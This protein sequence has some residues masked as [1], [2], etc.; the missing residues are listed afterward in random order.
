MGP[1]PLG[2]I[3]APE[4]P[5]ADERDIVPEALAIQE[6]IV[7]EEGS[8]TRAAMDRFF[9]DARIAPPR[10]MEFT[11]NESI[12]QAVI[13]NMGLAFVSLHTASLELQTGMLVVLDVI[14][15]PLVRAWHVVS[16]EDESMSDAAESLRRFIV[17]FSGGFI[18]RQFGG[19][20]RRIGSMHTPASST[21]ADTG[22]RLASS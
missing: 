2:I 11:S 21:A 13:G 6:F 22:T 10:V 9:K 4:H 1:Q 5:L 17:E 3:A 14:G 20:D 15:L 7:R 8:G 12:K 18:E 16:P 19:L